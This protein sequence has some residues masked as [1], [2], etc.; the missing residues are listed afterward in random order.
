MNYVGI[1]P[2]AKKR[3]IFRARPLQFR[4]EAPTTVLSRAATS[5]AKAFNPS[6]KDHSE[7]YEEY[8]PL[9]SAS[10]KILNVLSRTEQ[11]S[12]RSVEYVLRFTRWR[13][14]LILYAIAFRVKKYWTH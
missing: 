7:K 14:A 12:S 9:M 11:K 3:F 1:M 2:D 4:D 13:L 5:R 8:P 6:E 10:Y